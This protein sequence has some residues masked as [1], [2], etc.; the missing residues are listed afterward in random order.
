[1][2]RIG[3]SI[4]KRVAFRD[5]TQEFSNTYY[6]ENVGLEPDVT[7]AEEIIDFIATKEKTWHSTDV[8]FVYARL[9]SA[10]GTIEQN[11]MIFEKA[12]TGA[13]ST[14]PNSNLDRERAVLVQW[15]AGLDT[16]GRK[17]YLRKWYHTCGA[18]GGSAMTADNLKNTTKLADAFRT[19]VVNAADGLSRVPTAQSFG[20]VAENG[21]TRDGGL[22]AADPPTC[23]PYLEH[24]QLG[25]QWRG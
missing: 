16:K 14:T 25:D 13:G 15:G 21:R 24:H 8:S 2:A 17:V 1:M 19:A 11:S 10:G 5:S 23:H 20:L 4:T 12:L 6:Y 9:W 18:W 3:V 7:L 22:L